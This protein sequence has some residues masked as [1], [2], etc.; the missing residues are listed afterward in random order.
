MR[1]SGIATFVFKEK[2]HVCALT[3]YDS[4]L[5]LSTLHYSYEIKPIPQV[6]VSKKISSQEYQLAQQ[7]INTLQHSTFDISAFKDRFLQKLAANIKKA[8]RVSIQT[9]PLA[10][11]QNR[12]KR[13]PEQVSFRKS[14]EESIKQVKRKKKS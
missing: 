7:L 14:L 6:K 4:V 1:T 2:D 12:Q 3:A 10:I 5:L 11:S 13:K 8:Q 9:K